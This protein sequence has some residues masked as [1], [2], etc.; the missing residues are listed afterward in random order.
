M[1]NLSARGIPLKRLPL[2][3]G[4]VFRPDIH[5]LRYIGQLYLE[6]PNAPK[7]LNYAIIIVKVAVRLLAN[8]DM[9]FYGRTR[10]H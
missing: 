10:F 6:N 3:N 5:V 7:F 2:E 9:N 4:S 1:A 8:V